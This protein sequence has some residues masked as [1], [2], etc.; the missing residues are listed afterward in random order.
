VFFPVA[1]LPGAVRWLAYVFPL[2]HGVDLSRAATLGVA[3]D[4][5][6]AVHLGYLALWAAG[7][8]WLAVRAFTRRLTV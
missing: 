7:G 1:Q 3:P 4:W 2:W 8:W 6:V 5:P